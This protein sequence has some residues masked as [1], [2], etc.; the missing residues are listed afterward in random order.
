[1]LQIEADPARV[2]RQKHAARRVSVETLHQLAALLGRYAAVKQH[3]PEARNV[4]PADDQLMGAH[5]LAENHRLSLGALEQFAEQRGQFVHLGAV[6]S[7]VIEQIGAVAGHAHV[8]QRA[9]EHALV[10]LGQVISP[11]PAFHNF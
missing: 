5:P 1:M 6:V 10:G 11:A 3:V 7:L 2:G 8:L 4:Q 9:G